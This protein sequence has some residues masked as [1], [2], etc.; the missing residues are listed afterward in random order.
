MTK[1]IALTLMFFFSLQIPASSHSLWINAFESRVH[2]PSHVMVS[3]GWGHTLP[4]GDILTSPGARIG[5]ESF[6]VLAPD[7]SRVP[8]RIPEFKLSTPSLTD[9]NFDLYPADLGLQKLAFKQKSAPGVYQISLES[10]PTVYTKYISTAGKTRLKLKPKDELTD[11]KTVLMSV[12]YQAFAKSFVTLGPWQPPSA[13]GHRLEI[14][15]LTDLSCV[16]VNDLVT[17][18]VLFHNRP[19]NTTPAAKSSI[20]AQSGTFGQEDGFSLQAYVRNGQASIRIPAPG[21]WRIMV[22]HKEKVT[23]EGHLKDLMGKVDYVMCGSSLTF[24]VY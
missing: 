10:K 3:A 15:P 8:L 6:E 9:K 4:L 17:V 14:I 7:K 22:N 2:P 18:R 13:V 5:I 1:P 21:Q 12:K 20:F 24:K 11:I 19:L 23:A 16:K